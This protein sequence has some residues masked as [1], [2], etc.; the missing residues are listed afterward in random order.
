[1]YFYRS[2]NFFLKLTGIRPA[3]YILFLI[4]ISSI[5]EIILLSS[6]FPTI[7]YLVGFETRFTASI[8]HLFGI[9]IEADITEDQKLFIFLGVFSFFTV[10]ASIFRVLTLSLSSQFSF[11]TA[12]RFR[13]KLL[14]ALLNMKYSNFASLNS[15][16]VLLIMTEKISIIGPVLNEFFTF[17]NSLVIAVSI[18]LVLTF[19]SP[20]VSVCMLIFGFLYALIVLAVRKRLSSN[21]HK[22]NTGIKLLS[23]SVREGVLGIIDIKINRMEARVFNRIKNFSELEI[24]SMRSSWVISRIPRFFMEGISILII[25]ILLVLFKRLDYPDAEILPLFAVVVLGSQRTLPLMQ[26]AFHAYSYVS[27]NV[28]QI[29]EAES[30]LE[31]CEDERSPAQLSTINIAQFQNASFDNIYFKYTAEA[32]YVL[33][34]VS[35]TI[36]SGNF[37]ALTG[38]SGSGKSSLIKI[39]C[40]LVSA[41]TGT[42]KINNKILADYQTS[43]WFSKIGYVQQDVQLVSGSFLDNIKYVYGDKIDILFL[44]K[45][46]EIACLWDEIENFESG[47]NHEIGEGGMAISGGQKQR[48]G[49]VRALYKR[50]EILIFDEATNGLPIEIEL[51][52]LTNIKQQYKDLTLIAITHRT[53]NLGFYDSVIE[54]GGKN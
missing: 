17:L 11:R 46:C 7:T 35:L 3:L 47:I 21:S 28:A 12:E 45:C 19:F 39:L 13:N 50:P 6:I 15:N 20:L 1:M 34:G 5:L 22:Q 33:S 31:F 54:L 26:Q 29:S 38:P 25:A 41:D 53:E 18:F 42:L 10:L 43:D 44:K 40:G 37:Y 16:D 51:R 36:E 30:L 24:Q 9:Y 48:L 52:I 23:R 2:F 49:I 14:S 32:E 8:D 27:A 4:I